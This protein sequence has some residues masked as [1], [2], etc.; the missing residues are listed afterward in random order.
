[1]RESRDP[2]GRLT[3]LNGLDRPSEIKRLPI[4]SLDTK[5]GLPLN[6]IAPV[7]SNRWLR[8]MPLTAG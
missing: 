7:Y 6:E 2:S 8:E 1:M 3:Y 5:V 4:F